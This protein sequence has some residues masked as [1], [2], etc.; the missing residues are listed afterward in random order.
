MKSQLLK[1]VILPMLLLQT[2]CQSTP[3]CGQRLLEGLPLITKTDRAKHWPW[4][5][6]IFYN[7]SIPEYRCGGTVISS[8]LVLT[9][10]HCVAENNAQVN[11]SNVLVSLGRLNLDVQE[12]SAQ[13]FTVKFFIVSFCQRH[14]N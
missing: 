13:S 4:H 7:K 6:A 11:I 12:N 2:M 8:N 5:A 10:G 1:I 14:F 9:A 3:Q